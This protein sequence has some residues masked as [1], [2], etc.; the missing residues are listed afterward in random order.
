M[1]KVFKV[2]DIR[3]FERKVTL[4]EI[5][6]SRMVE[7]M[8]ERSYL[9]YSKGKKL[10]IRGVIGRYLSKV[11]WGALY[12]S[13]AGCLAGKPVYFCGSRPEPKY[14]YICVQCLND[15]VEGMSN[16]NKVR[17]FASL[18]FERKIAFKLWKLKR[19]I[20]WILQGKYREMKRT[21]F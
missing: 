16:K 12:D 2:A 5:S 19:N 18:W 10:P 8:N 9:A 20:G 15:A 11:N 7:E 17:I 3:E 13:Y 14:D 1:K 21:P 6:Y 4:G